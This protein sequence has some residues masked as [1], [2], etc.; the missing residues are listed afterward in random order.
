MLDHRAGLVAIAVLGLVLTA[1]TAAPTA[2]IRGPTVAGQPR[3]Y[4]APGTPDDPWG[5]YIQEAATRF[6]VPSPWIRAVMQQESGGRQYLDGQLTT[7]D[8]G[9]MGL[10]QLMPETYADMQA[11][12]ALG[13]DG[14]EP[15][16]NIMAGT[17]YIRQMYDRFGSPDFLAAYNAGPDRVQAWRLNG[18]PLP[19]ETIAYVAAITPG[20]G[21]DQPT[22][23]A[24]QPSMGAMMLARTDATEGNTAYV[25]PAV[26]TPLSRTADGCLRDADAA[27]DPGAP[28]LMDRDTPHDGAGDGMPQTA[29]AG[30]GPGTARDAVLPDGAV[31]ATVADMAPS[32]AVVQA[33]RYTVPDAGSW[34]LQVGA[35]S[36]N[37]EARHALDTT[38]ALLG[39]AQQ[40]L[41]AVVMPVA[42]GTGVLYRARLLGLGAATASQACQTLHA[43]AM[44]CLAVPAHT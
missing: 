36:T 2:T 13:S 6:A 35:F 18:E 27:Y 43:H 17:A 33:V 11:Q 20:L 3:I 10:M 21:A 39:V 24:G 38:R 1:C 9:A 26:P 25:P 37:A 12:Y 31:P 40:P 23:H 5:P 14:Y 16:D 28:C 22:G 29:S 44:A 8:A 19:A 15:H 42:T 34:A 4:T 30:T 32:P 7:S 41:A